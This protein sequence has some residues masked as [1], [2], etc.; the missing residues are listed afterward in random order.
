MLSAVLTP[1]FF[2]YVINIPAFI[3]G[4]ALIVAAEK[5]V[6]DRFSH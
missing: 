6:P 2:A 3:V 1:T 4:V 5:V